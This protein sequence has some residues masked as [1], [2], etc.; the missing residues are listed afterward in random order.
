MKKIGKVLENAKANIF[1][2]FVAFASLYRQAIARTNLI[3]TSLNFPHLMLRHFFEATPEAEEEE[4]DKEPLFPDALETDPLLSSFL[5]L[6]PAAAT[7][8]V[9]IRASSLL[10]CK[11]KHESKRESKHGTSTTATACMSTEAKWRISHFGALLRLYPPLDTL[12]IDAKYKVFLSVC[13]VWSFTL[14]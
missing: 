8:H 6:G 4:E 5:G 9:D 11:S 1:R 12:S 7:P 3:S 2:D 14:F 10:L 13:F